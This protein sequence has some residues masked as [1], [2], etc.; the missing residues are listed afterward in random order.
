MP[1]TPYNHD[2]IILDFFSHL[3]KL[4]YHQ[5]HLK[6]YI[7]IF[8]QRACHNL[9]S[10]QAP[11]VSGTPN[12]RKHCTF[13]KKIPTS[14]TN[15]V[16][17]LIFEF[18]KSCLLHYFKNTKFGK[19]FHL[20]IKNIIKNIDQIYICIGFGLALLVNLFHEWVVII[21]QLIFENINILSDNERT[22][23]FSIWSY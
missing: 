1:T 15:C 19:M 18:F 21:N 4:Y 8:P 11:L 23:L 10:L 22:K 12:I 6:C 3:S 13:S 14:C 5:N 2:V 9:D 7:Y 16:V 17:W 20:D